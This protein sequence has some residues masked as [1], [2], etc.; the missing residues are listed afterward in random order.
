MPRP[1]PQGQPPLHQGREAAAGQ[2]PQPAAAGVQQR[3]GADESEPQALRQRFGQHQLQQLIAQP[4]LNKQKQV[5]SL[6]RHRRPSL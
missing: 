2:A 6:L 3:L 4:P 5:L 1:R